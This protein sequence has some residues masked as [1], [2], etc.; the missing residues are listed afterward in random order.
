MVR[1]LASC[2]VGRGSVRFKSRPGK[3]LQSTAGSYHDLKIWNLLQSGQALGIVTVARKLSNADAVFVG[4]WVV[5]HLG[6]PS[7]Q[8]HRRNGQ[9]FQH[10]EQI[11][12]QAIVEDNVSFEDTRRTFVVVQLLVLAT[13]LCKNCPQMFSC[14][15]S[16]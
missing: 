13:A 8:R 9:I 15:L 4:V 10:V 16:M 3:N 14:L 12:A 7:E 5:L 11:S 2:L 6:L 1:A